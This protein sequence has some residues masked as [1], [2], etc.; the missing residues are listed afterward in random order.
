MN[1]FFTSS[2]LHMTKTS[3]GIKGGGFI[4]SV[5]ERAKDFFACLRMRSLMRTNFG[6]RGCFVSGQS[7][8]LEYL[9]IEANPSLF[10][11]ANRYLCSIHAAFLHYSMLFAKSGS[12]NFAGNKFTL[13]LE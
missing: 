5:W 8:I 2:K 3:R 10:L 9:G 7:D 13:N 12:P 11:L 4:H 6:K 1:E